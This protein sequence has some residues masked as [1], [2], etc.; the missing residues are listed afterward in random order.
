MQTFF[1]S[2]FRAALFCAALALCAAPIA[3]H[4]KTTEGLTSPTGADELPLAL[5]GVA[6]IDIVK[7][8]A[9]L[10]QIQLQAGET[11]PEVIIPGMVSV[12]TTNAPLAGMAPLSVNGEIQV[13]DSGIACIAANAGAQRFVA[14]A[15]VMEYCDGSTWKLFTPVQIQ[16]GARSCGGQLCGAAG[17]LTSN[18]LQMTADHLCQLAGYNQALSWSAGGGTGAFTFWDGS[19]WVQSDQSCT[20]TCSA[21][22]S[23]LCQ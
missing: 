7:P 18:N 14:S 13:G 3:A 19:K 8:G 20:T 12:G 6:G 5:N 1:S 9:A 16:V 10:S 11:R 4:A 23:V 17:G 22:T 2:G 21:W 15:K